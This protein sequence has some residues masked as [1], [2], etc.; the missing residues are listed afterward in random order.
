MIDIAPPPHLEGLPRDD[1]GFIVPAESPW[2]DG[3]PHL[4]SY[5]LMRTLGL[6]VARGCAV[7]GLPFPN[8]SLFWRVFTQRDAAL[9]R[10]DGDHTDDVG[11]PGHE[12]CMLYSTL[13][14]P[15]WRMPQSRLSKESLRAPGAT[16]GTKPSLLAYRHMFFLAED[17]KDVVTATPPA[18]RF[19][20]AA[21]EADLR[22][23]DARDELM[24]R[25]SDAL[26]RDGELLDLMS[27]GRYYW[28]DSESDEK[29]L[30]NLL[31][32]ELPLLYA[33]FEGPVGGGGVN[34]GRFR[35]KTAGEPNPA[36]AR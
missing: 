13:V 14:C 24:D 11:V 23:T 34:F 33:R 2:V 12:S 19:L 27:V 31:K 29:H 5:D 22:F 25:Y 28:T 16:R 26:N 35:M 18:F 17:G 32:D 3:V 9:A 21:R 7:C 15:F 10:L 4:A 8:G 20:Y 36:W 1:R 6:G 30:A